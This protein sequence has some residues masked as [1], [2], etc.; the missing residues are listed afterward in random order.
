MGLCVL[1]KHQGSVRWA[2]PG[3]DHLGAVLPPLGV[4]QHPVQM[5]GKSALPPWGDLTGR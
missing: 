5:C 1:F 4:A 2:V 3:P